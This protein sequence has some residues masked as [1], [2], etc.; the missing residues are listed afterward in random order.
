M[1]TLR[2]KYVI[3]FYQAI[4][5]TSRHYI[6]MELAPCGDV[7]EWIQKSGA[8]SEALAGKWFSQLALGIAYL[9]GKGIVHRDLKLENLLLDKRENIKISDFGFS[10]MVSTQT[11]PPPTPSYRM[12]SCFSHLSQTYCGSFAYACPEI[13][14]GLPYNPF[15]SDI[16]SMGVIL[17]TLVVAHLP[18]DDTNLKKLLRE[19]QKEVNF[20]SHLQVNDEIKD[21]VHRI[22]RPASKRLNILEVLKVSWVLKFLAEKPTNEIKALEAICGPRTAEGNKNTTPS[23]KSRSLTFAPDKKKA[24][25]RTRSTGQ[26]KGSKNPEKTS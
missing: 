16:W 2:H 14:L 1:K 21:L 10:K 23:T 18:F 24:A 6:I 17:Y 20:P 19:T 11:Q 15:L 13:L 5:T 22:L 7:L 9:H 8:C 26:I 25:S 12:M 4:E 3:S